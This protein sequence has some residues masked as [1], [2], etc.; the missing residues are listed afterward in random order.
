WIWAPAARAVPVLSDALE[1]V[2]VRHYDVQ[3]TFA[4]DG[5]FEAQEWRRIATTPGLAGRPVEGNDFRPADFRT[6]ML[7]EHDIDDEVDPVA[8]GEC[9]NYSNLRNAAI[10]A[11]GAGA[12]SRHGAGTQYR[13]RILVTRRRPAQAPGGESAERR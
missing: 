3:F 2:F 6:Q 12:A 10:V 5:L 13:W 4:G 8:W 11:A 7:D 9:E 1:E